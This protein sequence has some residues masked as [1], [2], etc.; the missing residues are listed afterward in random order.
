MPDFSQLALIRGNIR[1]QYLPFVLEPKSNINASVS[2]DSSLTDGPQFF[3]FRNKKADQY[4]GGFGRLNICPSVMS[5]PEFGMFFN[6]DISNK[7][8]YDYGHGNSDPITI[9]SFFN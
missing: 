1:Q 7:L 3:S 5:S 8:L 2:D 9:D 6:K 4:N